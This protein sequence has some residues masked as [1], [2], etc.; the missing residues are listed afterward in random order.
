M[1]TPG[2]AMAPRTADT[3][4]LPEW[5]E[6]LA[7]ADHAMREQAAHPARTVVLLPYLQLVPL[8]RGYWAQQFPQGFAPHFET[9]RT[10]AERVGS[11]VAGPTDLSFNHGR[12]LLVARGLLEGAGLAEH[13][14]VLAGPLMQQALSLATVAAAMPPP[15]RP[16]WAEH[17][18]AV[19]PSL[20]DD[21]LALE[22]A[23]ARIAIAWAAGSDYL[24]DVLFDRGTVQALDALVIVAGLQADPLTEILGQHHLEKA[25]RLQLDGGGAR[26]RVLLHECTDSEDEAERA[27]ACVLQHLRAGR[28]PVGLVA[29]DRALTR[30]VGALLSA[31]G[32]RS[33]QVLSDETGWK[34]STTQ[35]AALVLGA[36]RA[37]MA[38]AS[39]DDVLAWLQL[40]PAFAEQERRAL[41]RLLRR[42]VVRNWLQAESV[43]ADQPL[44]GRV[45]ALRAGM[46]RARPL[47]DWLVAT[48]SLLQ[49]AG[50][51]PALIKDAAGQKIMATLGMADD[52][53]ALWQDVPV[54]ERRMALHEFMAWCEAALEAARF[55]PPR[56]G[57]PRVVVLPLAQLLGRPLAAVVLSGADEQ[58]LPAAPEPPGPW[59]VPQREHLHLPTRA[60]LQREQE[61]AWALALRAPVLDVLWRSDDGRGNRL[62]PS[63]LVQVLQLQ[64]DLPAR[65]STPD[66]RRLRS[67][68]AAPVACPAPGGAGL[69]AQPLSA[70]GYHMLRQ[71]PYRFF[72]LRLLGLQEDSELDVDLQKRDWGNWVHLVLRYFH[73]ALKEQPQAG[74]RALIDEAAQRATQQLGLDS[75]EFLPYS[76]AWPALRDAY[77]PWLQEHEN[78]GAVFVD[79]EA[80]FS[81][82]RGGLRLRGRLDRVDRAADGTPLLI[83]YKTESAQKTRDR[84]KAG[85]E[86]TQLPFY[87]LLA[88]GEGA[89][90]GYL[91]LAERETPRLYPL[92]H[93]AEL[94]ALLQ[95]GMQDDLQRVQ[96][97]APLPALGQGSVCDWCEVRG[98]C[99]KDFWS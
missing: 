31:R 94:A 34:L 46:Q 44:V 51:W 65:P 92:A 17:A 14:A 38:T 99:R 71:C 42:K 89:N 54:A 33:G 85:A 86:D 49:A 95:R 13:A 75:G 91:N 70:S 62:L 8:A 36:L 40:A 48:Q 11:F 87:L 32:V 47:Q 90:A 67:V 81:V 30:R 97:G 3:A 6:L 24:T 43:A 22:A 96:A 60:D 59:T 80:D 21:A 93:P 57:N 98:L 37:C 7:R 55:E 5:S 74:R 12:D 23:L 69:P 82:E 19:L 39:T 2:A 78:A 63:P 84:I 18:R 29:T 1:N 10:W 20:A 83:D 9:T 68:R 66:P 79:A 64:E 27:T 25:V 41:E 50:Q 52:N 56:A 88:G 61:A 15:L 72:A 28:A 76:A 4:I 58:N 73:E 77:L 26:G 53:P 35:S 45:T 16:D